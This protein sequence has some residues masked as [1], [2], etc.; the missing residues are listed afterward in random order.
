[1]GNQ[2]D[3]FYGQP[4][5]EGKKRKKGPNLNECKRFNNWD[6]LEFIPN[7]IGAVMGAGSLGPPKKVH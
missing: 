4:I 2:I 7:G 5:S 1:L 3:F 6:E